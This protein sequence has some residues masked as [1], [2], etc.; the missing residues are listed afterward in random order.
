MTQFK[1]VLIEKLESLKHR[2]IDFH[3]L[4]EFHIDSCTHFIVIQPSE[5]NNKYEFETYCGNIL[6][7]L[8][9]QF[10]DESLAFVTKDSLIELNNTEE[11]FEYKLPE[12]ITFNN[13]VVFVESSANQIHQELLRSSDI[14]HTILTDAGIES[15]IAQGY[16]I[17]ETK[18][19]ESNFA[20][21]A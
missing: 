18:A 6:L 12:Y 13:D 11:I 15:L 20:M 1:H 21:A 5:L 7:E 14:S 2:F 9:E 17:D 19:D 16:F 8:M 10:P 3:P 4:Y